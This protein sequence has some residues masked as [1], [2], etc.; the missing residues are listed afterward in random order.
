MS[1][2][3]SANQQAAPAGDGTPAL[4]GRPGRPWLRQLAI[5]LAALGMAGIYVGVILHNLDELER[6]RTEFTELQARKILLSFETHTV[7]L[8]DLADIYL[9]SAREFAQAEGAGRLERFVDRVVPPGSEL[10][11]STLTL[12]DPRGR[13]VFSTDA[14]LARGTD[15]SD[16]D[17]FLTFRIDPRDRIVIGTANH[18]TVPEEQYFHVARPLLSGG[19]LAGV[20][21]LDVHSSRIAAFYR[22]MTLG[23]NSSAAIFS[24]DRRMIARQPPPVADSAPLGDLRIWDDVAARAEGSFHKRSAL[25][26]IERTFLFKRVSDYPLVVVVGFADLDIAEGLEGARRAEVVETSLF[27]LTALAFAGLAVILMGRNRRLAEA[28][29]ASRATA[30]LLE[31]SNADLERFAYVASHDLKTPL[32][33]ITGY[34]QMLERRYRDRLD[35]EANEYIAFLTSGTKRMY[36]LITDLLHYSRINSQAKPLEPVSAARAADIAVGN[37]KAVIEDADA[38]VTVGQLPV[39]L[40][41]ESQLSSLFQNLVGNALKYRHPDRRPDIRVTATRLSSSIWRFAVKDNGIGIEA[42]HFERI[43]VI[44]QRLHA[45]T[46]YEGTGIGLALCQRIVTRLGG[47]IWVESTPGEGSTFFFTAKDA[48]RD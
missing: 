30:E 46:A 41:D 17:P 48:G 15:L 35:D 14:G 10:Y 34:A 26:G 44:F 32:R 13:V 12:L 43:F 16:L 18:S 29:R 47:R 9:R 1:Q 6:E 39:I 8:F 33:V 21:M 11:S 5:A 25:D 19:G 24:L 3:P 20:I 2:T 38:M 23:A 27:G 42:E 28:D 36:R 37:L 40:A 7:R 22:D 31:R 4:T 45:D